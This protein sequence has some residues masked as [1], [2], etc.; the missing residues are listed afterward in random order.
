MGWDLILS[1]AK[2]LV[3]KVFQIFFVVQ[4]YLDSSE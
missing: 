4:M 3:G 1:E 2:D